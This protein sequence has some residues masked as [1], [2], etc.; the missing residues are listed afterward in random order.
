M[1][2][3]I[4]ELWLMATYDDNDGTFTRTETT[5]ACAFHLGI[6]GWELASIESAPQLEA[7]VPAEASQP[8]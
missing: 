2:W 8:A 1:S 6:M 3:A 5:G 4:K 7:V